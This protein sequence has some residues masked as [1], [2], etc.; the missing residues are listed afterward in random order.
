[1]ATQSDVFD[2]VILHIKQLSAIDSARVISANDELYLDLD[3]DSPNEVMLSVALE[4]EF[5]F[6][7]D[8]VTMDLTFIFG[9]VGNLAE[10]I[11]QYLAA[12]DAGP[13]L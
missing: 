2:R 5:G 4:D 8:P 7:F 6:E 13:S 11:Y 3:I 10:F 12:K 1:M 9:T